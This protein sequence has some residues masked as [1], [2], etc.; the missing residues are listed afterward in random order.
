M[1]VGEMVSTNPGHGHGITGGLVGSDMA[2]LGALLRVRF[3]LDVLIKLLPSASRPTL[4]WHA[5]FYF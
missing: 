2:E 1:T 5:P 3:G 4:P